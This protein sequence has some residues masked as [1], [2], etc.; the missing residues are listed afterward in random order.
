MPHHT[1]TFPY[2]VAD[3]HYNRG[4]ISVGDCHKSGNSVH[5]TGFCDCRVGTAAFSARFFGGFCVGPP[6]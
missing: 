3:D 4:K 2:S 5:V 1:Q 6:A